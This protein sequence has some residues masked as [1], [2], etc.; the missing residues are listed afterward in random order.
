[1]E[2][3]PVPKVVT[4]AEATESPLPPQIQEAL[5][6]LVGPAREGLVALS[7]GV[8]LSA[9]HELMEREVEQVVGRR[10]SGIRIAPPRA[11]A[12]RRDR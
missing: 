1:M 9:V 7:V 10:A 2:K 11:T 4:T 5:G 3:V 8:G 12:M 6:E